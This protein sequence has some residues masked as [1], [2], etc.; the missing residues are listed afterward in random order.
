MSERIDPVLYEQEYA[1][2]HRRPDW[3]LRNVVA[4]LNMLPALNG[5]REYA[6]LAAIAS[7]KRERRH[8]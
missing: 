5:P 7:I 8:K 1:A 4:A 3:E 2:F 6:R